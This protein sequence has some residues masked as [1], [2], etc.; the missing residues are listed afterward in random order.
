[1][2]MSLNVASLNV[3]VSKRNSSKTYMSQNVKKSQFVSVILYDF[4]CFETLTFCD[5]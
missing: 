4:L 2:F 5:F 3:I 1:M